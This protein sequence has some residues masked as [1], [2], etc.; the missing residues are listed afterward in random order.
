MKKIAVNWKRRLRSYSSL[1]IIANIMVALSVTGLTVLGVISSGIAFTTV[2]TSAFVL[3]I[4]G[5][6]GRVLNEAIGD[7]IA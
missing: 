5:L 3:G 2:I 1:S 4:M 6:I 7:G